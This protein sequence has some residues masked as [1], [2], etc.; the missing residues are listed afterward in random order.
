[1]EASVDRNITEDEYL[2]I[3]IGAMGKAVGLNVPL[4]LATPNNAGHCHT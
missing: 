4:Q 2:I 1:M 3:W